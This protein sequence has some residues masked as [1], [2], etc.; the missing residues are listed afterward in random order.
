MCGEMLKII[1]TGGNDMTQAKGFNAQFI[2]GVETEFGEM[3]A[4]AAGVKLPVNSAQIKS[5]QSF[6]ETD[7]ITGNRSSAAPARGNI[8]VAGTVVIPVDEEAIGYWLKAMFG[9]P[10][11]TP[12]ATGQTVYTHLFT[13]GLEQASLVL[14]QGFPDIGVFELFNGCKINKFALNLGGDAELTASID[15]IG[16]SEKIQNA[17]FCAAPVTV[18]WSRYSNF[19]ASLQEGGAA[20]A[21]VTN[22]SLNVEF[23]LGGDNYTIG[24]NGFRTAIPEGIIKVSGEIKAFFENKILLDKAIN[25]AETSLAFKLTNSGNSLEFVLGEVVYERNSPVIEGTKG[26]VI[27][28]PY[29][30]YYQNSAQGGIITATLVNAKTAY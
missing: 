12:P 30:A 26:I 5:K 17:S 22:A 14:E 29:R 20:L 4:T 27:D 3:P 19:Q 24:G 9:N 1:K 11:T 28:L 13:P 23:G 7:T 8:D 16:A 18:N 6:I 2:M 10:T 25:G 21:T 15:V